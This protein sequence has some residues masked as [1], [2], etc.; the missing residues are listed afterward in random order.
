MYGH[1]ISS[2]AASGMASEDE[3]QMQAKGYK[4]QIARMLIINGIVFFLLHLIV[5]IKSLNIS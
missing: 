2:L 1:I 4:R 5:S 3:G